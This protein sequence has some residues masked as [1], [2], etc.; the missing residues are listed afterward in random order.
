NRAPAPTKPRVAA[1]S[2]VAS[3]PLPRQHQQLSVGCQYFA[4]GVLKLASGIDA[5]LY[6]FDPGLGDVVDLL[7]AVHHESQ[8]PSRMAS[9]L[10][11]VAGRLAAVQMGKRA[12][13]GGR[14]G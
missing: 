4:H 9:T 11:A 12:R 2:V 10:P 1:D 8:R 14:I 6:I 3:P 13:R 5:L 7:L